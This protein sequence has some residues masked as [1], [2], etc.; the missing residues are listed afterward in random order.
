MKSLIKK[1][2]R[3]LSKIINFNKKYYNFQIKKIKSILLIQ[4]IYRKY[5]LNKKVNIY[6]SLPYEIKEHIVYITREEQRY[7]NY[8]KTLEKILIKKLNNFCLEHFNTIDDFSYINISI[9]L[10]HIFKDYY[11]KFAIIGPK[12][13][14]NFYLIVKYST[15]LIDSYDFF[16]ND[17]ILITDNL[18]YAYP[19]IYKKMLI[20]ADMILSKGKNSF[21]DFDNYHLHGYVNLMNEIFNS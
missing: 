4:K 14:Y 8:K 5:K 15:I 10:Y 21:R 16:K 18:I 6:K 3:I 1:K 11:H 9:Y 2:P 7:I 17:V 13:L 19:G 12:I 20:I